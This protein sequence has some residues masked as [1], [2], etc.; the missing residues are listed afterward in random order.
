MASHAGVASSPWSQGQVTFMVANL[1]R[2]W[3]FYT[4]TLGLAPGDR[5]GDDYA[6][7][8]AP[9]MEIGFHPGREH[10]IISD[11]FTLSLG[12]GDID[13]AVAT[14]RE[15]GVGLGDIE[16]DAAGRSIN[17]HDPGGN[18]I[19]VREDWNKD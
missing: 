10:G 5:W 7:V 8:K 15:R 14:L 2:A 17:F 11:G 16:D 19:H 9:G 3:D 6:V 12:T 1:D 13:G 4:E 18:P